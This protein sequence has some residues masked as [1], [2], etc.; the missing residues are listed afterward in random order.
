MSRSFA[1]SWAYSPS[2]LHCYLSTRS[3]SESGTHRG[4]HKTGGH[5]TPHLERVS[6]G[7]SA[8]L[9]TRRSAFRS[10]P[11][12][13]TRRP[14]R[15]IDLHFGHRRLLSVWSPFSDSLPVGKPRPADVSVSLPRPAVLGSI[16]QQF[17][18]IEQGES[19]RVREVSDPAHRGEECHQPVTVRRLRIGEAP[20]PEILVSSP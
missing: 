4:P 14:R 10:C 7:S 12:Y 1:S 13:Q 16:E 18:L 3:T 15:G 9:I 11:R 20:L 5:E 19:T 8:G 17:H 2:L 6:S